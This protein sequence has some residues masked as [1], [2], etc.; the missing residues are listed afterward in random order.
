MFAHSLDEQKKEPMRERIHQIITG[1]TPLN[2]LDLHT[3]REIFNE[4]MIHTRLCKKCV[5]GIC[6]GGYNCKFGACVSSHLICQ[7]DLLFGTCNNTCCMH[8]I[9]L[10][11]RGLIPY[12]TRVVAESTNSHYVINEDEE[13]ENVCVKYHYKINA[14]SIPLNSETAKTISDLAN[15]S[16]LD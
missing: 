11:K 13:D 16:I 8:G 1:D 12:N 9:H 2:E 3:S 5:F 15:A 7:N 4:L 14:L 10:T 6:A